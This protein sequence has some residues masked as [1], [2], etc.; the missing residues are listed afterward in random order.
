[1]VRFAHC[2]SDALRG[3]TARAAPEPATYFEKKIPGTTGGAGRTRPLFTS[4]RVRVGQDQGLANGR[5]A[6]QQPRGG[7]LV[8]DGDDLASHRQTGWTFMTNHTHILVCL[9]RGPTTTVR[10][11][12]L[13]VGITERSVQRI[14]AEL[15]NSGVVTRSWEGRCNRYKVQHGFPLR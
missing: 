13:Q 3:E 9:S 6:G 2:V 5:H 8:V 15:E 7:F 14:L 12:A 10:N 1:M 4:L 11:L